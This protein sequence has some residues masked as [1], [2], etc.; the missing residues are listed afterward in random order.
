M[1]HRSTPLLLAG[2]LALGPVLSGCARSEDASAAEEAAAPLP[3]KRTV[4]VETLVLAPASFTEIVEL[5]GAVETAFDATLSAETAGTILSLAPLGQA[6]RQ[7]TVVAELDAELARAAVEQARAQVEAAQA[8]YELAEDTFRRQEPLY[9]D[10]IISAIE[11]ENVRTQRN[12]AKAQLAQARAALSQAEEQLRQT[13]IRAPFAG[14]VEAHLVEVGEQVMPGTPVVRLVNTDRVKV[15]AGVPERYANDIEAG[16]PVEV[17][18]KAYGMARRPARVTFAGRV[19][20]PQNRTFRIE[21]ELD[22]RDGRLKPEMIAEVYLTRA[23]Y[24]NRLVVPQTAVLRDEN[25]Q[26]M[27]VVEQEEAQRVARRRTVTLGPSYGGRVVVEEG[28]EPGDEVIVVGQTKVTEGDAVEV[29]R[30]D[31]SLAAR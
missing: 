2:L 10:S 16:T 8:Q 28:L 25:G 9:R 11:F 22:N 29:V 17:G 18:F 20:N 5:T 27:Y 15:V 1:L 30:R 24:E 14:T 4:R 13:R 23:T 21:I 6:V 7:G 12:Q 31:S 3:G 26:T 19:I